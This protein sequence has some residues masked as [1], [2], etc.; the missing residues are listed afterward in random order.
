MANGEAV[1]SI[2]RGYHIHPALS[3]LVTWTLGALE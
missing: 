3:E 2:F 1:D